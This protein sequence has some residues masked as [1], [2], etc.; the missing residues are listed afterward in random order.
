MISDSF[1]P[2]EKKKEKKREKQIRFG[3]LS[4]K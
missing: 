4:M 1:D 3:P 2:R